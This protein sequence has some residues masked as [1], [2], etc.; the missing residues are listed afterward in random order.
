MWWCEVSERKTI[1]QQERTGK[2]RGEARL[3]FGGPRKRM[4]ILFR[5]RRLGRKAEFEFPGSL[6]FPED[7]ANLPAEPLRNVREFG[8]PRKTSPACGFQ[9]EFPPN[10]MRK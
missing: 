9:G 7:I 8:D 2:R 6:D 1:D 10:S 3:E 5:N 4:P